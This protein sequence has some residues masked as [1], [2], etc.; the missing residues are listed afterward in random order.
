[1]EKRVT[2]EEIAGAIINAN[3]ILSFKRIGKD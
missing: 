2:N 1:M 3:D